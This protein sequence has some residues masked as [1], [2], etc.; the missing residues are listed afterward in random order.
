MIIMNCLEKAEEIY[1]D[2]KKKWKKIIKKE[3]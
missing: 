3:N 1:V 2:E